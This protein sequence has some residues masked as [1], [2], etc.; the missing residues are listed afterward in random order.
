MSEDRELPADRPGWLF[1]RG[2]DG[3]VYCQ[4]GLGYRLPAGFVWRED[5]ADAAGNF[6]LAVRADRPVTLTA[7]EVAERCRK[8]REDMEGAVVVSGPGWELP[9]E[10]PW[11]KMP[12]FEFKPILPPELPTHPD[13]KI[14]LPLPGSDP[15]LGAAR[16]MP[17]PGQE[18][19]MAKK[20]MPHKPMPHK[21]GKGGKH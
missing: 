12:T 4:V 1:Y 8:L 21:P 18:P 11:R 6:Q 3:R 20:S 10:K 19:H 13:A 16:F 7:T 17:P 2:V 14:T 9:D 5:V 15:R